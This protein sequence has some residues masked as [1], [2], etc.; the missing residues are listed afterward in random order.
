MRI[1]VVGAGAMGSIFGARFAQGGHETVLVDVAEPL[2]E[3]INADGVVVVRG[4]E[5]TVTHLPATTDPAL[6][7]PGRP[8]RLLRQVLPHRLRGRA[9][10]PARGPRH[11]RR[12]APERLGQRRRPR[13]RLPAGADRRRRHVQQRHGARAR[14]RRPSWRRPDD[15][16]ARSPATRRRAQSGSPQPSRTAASRLRWPRR[17]ARR[18]GRS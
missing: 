17:S 16:G 10:A 1:A 6:R 8:R 13:G 14:S 2:V 15:D 18:S 11:R 9:R 5:E 4:D 7:R 3:K 12:L